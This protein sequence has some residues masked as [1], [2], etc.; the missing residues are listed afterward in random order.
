MRRQVSVSPQAVQEHLEQD[1]YTPDQ[2]ARSVSLLH[3]AETKRGVRGPPPKTRQSEQGQ[4][5]AEAEIVTLSEMFFEK[6]AEKLPDTPVSVPDLI[7]SFTGRT[8][9]ALAALMR[10]EDK[11][12]AAQKTNAA[13]DQILRDSVLLSSGKFALTLDSI[14]DLRT[15]D[16]TRLY[17]AVVACA[18]EYVKSIRPKEVTQMSPEELDEYFVHVSRIDPRLARVLQKQL[19]D[20]KGETGWKREMIVLGILAIVESL[21][22]ETMNDEE[23]PTVSLTREVHEWMMHLFNNDTFTQAMHDG[24]QNEEVKR[25]IEEQLEDLQRKVHGVVPGAPERSAEEVLTFFHQWRSPFICI[26]G[27]LHG[28]GLIELETIAPTTW[29]REE[30]WQDKRKEWE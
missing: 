25:I 13:I 12:Q 21:A 27:S 6:W 10:G 23:K 22:S 3:A 9:Y 19:P 18:T 11:M 15:Q 20:Y 8:H 16:R 1:R 30:H 17:D 7:R 14:Q 2:L 4:S 24:I 26:I 5:L 29:K 28:K